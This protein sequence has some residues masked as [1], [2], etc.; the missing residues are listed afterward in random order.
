MQDPPFFYYCYALR[1][2]ARIKVHTSPTPC[3]LHNRCLQ[4]TSDATSLNFPHEPILIP[5]LVSHHLFAW[6][7]ALLSRA[8]IGSYFLARRPLPIIMSDAS[9]IPNLLSLRGRGGGRRGQGRGRGGA[10]ASPGARHDSTI[11]GT[12][13]DAAVSRLSAVDVGYLSD[14]Y[15]QF[16]VQSMGPSQRRL[17]IINRGKFGQNTF[18]LGL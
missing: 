5:F 12:D 4:L 7:K 16:F 14:P 18:T 15:A 1:A 13:N 9:Q 10:Q 17:P 3:Q 2:R 8:L 11:Q 6:H